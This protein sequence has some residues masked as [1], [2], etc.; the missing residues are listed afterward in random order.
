MRS[1]A[2]AQQLAGGS[3]FLI[4][5]IDLNYFISTARSRLARPSCPFYDRA[6][7]RPGVTAS[8]RFPTMPAPLG[9]FYG[10]Q[11][12]ATTRTAR[13]CHG[14]VASSPELQSKGQG[15]RAEKSRST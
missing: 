1:A 12:G 9:P 15:D 10:P 5:E 2:A 11:C 4:L 7:I 6:L 14:R 13:S 3:S 8:P